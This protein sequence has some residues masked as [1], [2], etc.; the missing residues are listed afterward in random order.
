M[1][2]GTEERNRGYYDKPNYDLDSNNVAQ[3]N[4]TRDQYD[5]IRQETRNQF[6]DRHKDQIDQSIIVEETDSKWINDKDAVRQLNENIRLRRQNYDTYLNS[7]NVEKNLYNRERNKTIYL[8]CANVLA[9]G[10]C[11]FMWTS[12]SFS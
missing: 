11:I 5:D 1:A 12:V 8:A 4:L 9:L 7:V 6:E 2:Y 3:Y 10:G